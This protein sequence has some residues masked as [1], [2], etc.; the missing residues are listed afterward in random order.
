[1]K[2]QRERIGRDEQP[3]LRAVCARSAAWTPPLADYRLTMGRLAACLWVELRRLG[4]S[5]R[6]AVPA[7]SC[8]TVLSLLRGRVTLVPY[9]VTSDLRP[10]LEC[11]ERLH[12]ERSL[13]GVIVTEYFGSRTWTT[14]DLRCIT[15]FAPVLIDAAHALPPRERPTL[16][17]VSSLYSLRKV[18]PD[19]FGGRAAWYYDQ[20]GPVCRELKGCAPYPHDFLRWVLAALSRWWPR[21]LVHL[22]E[23][24]IES[25]GPDSL[26]MGWA[27]QVDWSWIEDRITAFR[28]VLLDAC[29]HASV[30]PFSVGY[31]PPTLAQPFQ[32]DDS[33]EA[34]ARLHRIGVHA[35]VWPHSAGYPFARYSEQ[36]NVWRR[37]TICVPLLHSSMLE[38]QLASDIALLLASRCVQ[39]SRDRRLDT[40]RERI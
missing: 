29:D 26:L 4:P 7:I 24:P 14:D 21:R 8:P 35:Y 9:S 11:I 37:R 36:M 20:N 1:M 13:G 38:P 15:S 23:D 2:Y 33:R 18:L 10:N 22:D 6:V 31:T 12:S 27:E 25:Q 17:G 3:T 28:G 16:S 40:A 32:V 5:D 39:L 34:L 30:R 19:G